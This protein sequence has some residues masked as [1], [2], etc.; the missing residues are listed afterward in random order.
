V[1]AL[2]AGNTVIRMLPAV[3]ITFEQLDKVTEALIEV[4]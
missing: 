1:L 2:P 3:T 4:L